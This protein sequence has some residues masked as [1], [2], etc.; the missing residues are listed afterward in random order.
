MNKQFSVNDISGAK[1]IYLYDGDT[2]FLIDEKDEAYGFGKRSTEW[3]HKENFWDYFESETMLYYLR[4]ISAE[5]AVRL[6]N[7]WEK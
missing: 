4:T 7:N 5:E 6:Y 2:I 3:Y 1:T